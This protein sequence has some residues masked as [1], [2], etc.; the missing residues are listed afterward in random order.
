[1]DQTVL[2]D[3]LEKIQVKKM[4][5]YVSNAAYKMRVGVG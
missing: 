2:N 3:A 5:R 1:M 4:E